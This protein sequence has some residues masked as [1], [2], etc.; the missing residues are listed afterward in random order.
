[1]KLL[2]PAQVLDGFVIDECIHNGSMAHVYT[3]HYNADRPAPSFPLVMKVPRMT[4]GDGG[5][6]IVGFEVEAQ[7][8]PVLTGCH[9]PRFVAA[10]DLLNWV[11]SRRAESRQISFVD[12]HRLVALMFSAMGLGEHTTVQLRQA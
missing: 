4:Q 5:E 6:N 12:V 2:E 9:V 1:M 11:L 7:I 10:G 3:V 8:M